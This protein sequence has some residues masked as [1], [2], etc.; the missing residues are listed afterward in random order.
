MATGDFKTPQLSNNPLPEEH[1]EYVIRRLEKFI[2]DG[3]TLDEGMSFRKWQSMAKTEIAVSITETQNN[4][5][6]DEI[7]SRRI[8]FVSASAMTTIG[9]WGTVISLEK[10]TYL[11]GGIICLIAG[12]LILFLASKGQYRRNKNHKDGI[13]RAS[14]LIKIRS[15]NNRIKKLERDLEEEEKKLDKSIEKLY[16]SQKKSLY[17]RFMTG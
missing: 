11:P 9:F 1:A 17:E 12:L 3:R 13:K 14:Q 6:Y 8:L 7:N 5:K 4:Y 10:V 2:R 15:L 16:K